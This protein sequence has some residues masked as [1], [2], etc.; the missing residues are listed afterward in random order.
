MPRCDNTVSRPAGRGETPRGSSRALLCFTL[1][2]MTEDH[3]DYVVDI[4]KRSFSNPWRRQDFQF[5]VARNG[6]HRLVAIREGD[7]IGFSIGFFRSGE[8]HLADFA[9]RADLRR[10]GVGRAFLGRLLEIIKW[11]SV[12]IVTLEVRASNA[13]AIALYRDA[14]FQ[15]VAVRR[16]YY[17]R[18]K[19]DALVMLKPL[20]E[21]A[22]PT[23]SVPP[24]P[25]A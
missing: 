5:A 20:R 16:D 24:S 14:G 9:V 15:T 12:R 11:R 13:P 4:E 19:E 21:G 3:L 18:P 1:A 17:S 2:E 22:S 25:E 8:F 10:R 6:A 23:A 7:V